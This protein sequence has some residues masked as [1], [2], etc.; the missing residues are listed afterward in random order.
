MDTNLTGAGLGHLKGLRR[1]RSLNL[2]GI[3]LEARYTRGLKQAI[4]GLAIH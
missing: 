2:G 3:P 1:L 4:P